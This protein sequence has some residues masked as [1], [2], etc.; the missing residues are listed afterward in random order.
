MGLSNDSKSAAL[1]GFRIPMVWCIPVVLGLLGLFAEFA[2]EAG[3]DWLRWD[4][5]GIADG[6]I[7]R[8]VTGHLVHMSWSHFVLNAVGLVL[9][10]LLVG[11]RFATRN[12][13]LVIVVAIA[14]MDLGFWFLETDLQWYVGMSGLLHGLLIAGLIIGLPSAGRESLVIA[15]FVIAKLIY[16]QSIGPLPGSESTSGGP[17]MVNAHLYG[18]LSATLAGAYFLIR[19][20]RVRA[21]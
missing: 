3:R 8:V 15:A 12:W 11:D 6:E 9:V 4:R 5:A 19:V 17:V 2:G 18:T 20:K 21:I 1:T 16:E 10:W 14:G 13:L 7:W